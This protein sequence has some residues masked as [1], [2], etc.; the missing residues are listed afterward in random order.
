MTDLL[1][2]LQEAILICAG[3]NPGHFTRSGLAKLLVG[4]ESSRVVGLTDD[5]D[6]G[7]LADLGRKA[8]TFEI[9]ILIQQGYLDLDQQQRVLPGPNFPAI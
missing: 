2:A 1:T 4:S 7:R 5:L 6:Y 9:D 8:I 3:R